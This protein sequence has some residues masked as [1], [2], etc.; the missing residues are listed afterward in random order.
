MNRRD[1][2]RSGAL[3]VLALGMAGCSGP[4]TQRAAGGAVR[5]T[6]DPATVTSQLA[7]IVDAS[8]GDPAR[9]AYRWRRNNEPLTRVAGPALDPDQFHK[10][11]VVAVDV[12]IPAIEGATARTLSA[13]VHVANAPPVI[14]EARVV[15]DRASGGIELVATTDCADPDG[16]ATTL[17]YRWFRNGQPVSGAVDARLSAAAFAREDHIAF[18]AVASDGEARS[19]PRR[20]EEFVLSN[21]APR[22][23][24]PPAT[25]PA[26][27]GTFRFQAQAADPDGDA[28]RFD[29]VSGPPGLTVTPGGAIEWS[30]PARD[31]RQPEYAVTIRATDPNGGEATQ[32]FAIRLTARDKKP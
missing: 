11:D 13:E 17:S 19:E 16:D 14:R 30:L 3:V 7:V 28:V 27:E 4:A 15:V 10:G 22:F 9:Y 31:Q 32:V 1:G 5:L 26:P 24:D 12:T 29:L 18:E 20:S 23:S 21:R 8:N 2:F 25:L 6:P